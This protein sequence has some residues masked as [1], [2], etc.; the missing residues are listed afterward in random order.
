MGILEGV[1]YVVAIL[2]IG[3]IALMSTVIA[4]L[5]VYSY[6]VAREMG[7]NI[8]GTVPLSEW[9]AAKQQG[10]ASFPGASKSGEAGKDAGHHG[11]YM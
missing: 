5:K 7:K 6:Y 2:G 4:G 9:L 3:W 11:R 1:F 8:I 10:G